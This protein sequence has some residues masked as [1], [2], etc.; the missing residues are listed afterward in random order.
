M[1]RPAGGTACVIVKVLIEERLVNIRISKNNH[2]HH[3]II[4]ITGL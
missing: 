2:G 3:L 4:S 1:E